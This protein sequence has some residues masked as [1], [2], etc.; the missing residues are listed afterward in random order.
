MFLHY[1]LFNEAVSRSECKT[2]N[3]ISTRE[4]Q[5]LPKETVLAY[6]E[7]LCWDF[8]RHTEENKFQ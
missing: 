6:F 4:F 7:E 5:R 3:C 1:S 8:P 2:S